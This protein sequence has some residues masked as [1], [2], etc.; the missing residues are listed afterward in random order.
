MKEAN[1][2]VKQGETH[3]LAVRAVCPGERCTGKR[4]THHAC[5]S[6]AGVPWTSLTRCATFETTSQ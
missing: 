5:L 4:R 2:Q 6:H 3:A 1:P